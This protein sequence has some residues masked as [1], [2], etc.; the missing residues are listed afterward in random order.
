MQV[1]GLA[2]SSCVLAPVVT[3]CYL[4]FGVK[5]FTD[6]SQRGPQADEPKTVADWREARA[7]EGEIVRLQDPGGGGGNACRAPHCYKVRQMLH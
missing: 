4:I 6:C 2:G 5:L 7:A 3:R 1:V